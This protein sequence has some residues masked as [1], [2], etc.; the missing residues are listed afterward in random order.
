M[1]SVL[2]EGFSPR[3]K[4]RESPY[5]LSL[6][7]VRLVLG[8]RAARTDGNCSLAA[9]AVVG[10]AAGSPCWRLIFR[11]AV[12][13][14][15]C[16]SAA[17]TKELCVARALS[18]T[19]RTCRYKCALVCALPLSEI[20]MAITQEALQRSDFLSAYFSAETDRRLSGGAAPTLNQQTLP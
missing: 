13:G 4:R 5:P 9:A 12:R 18:S 15:F 20:V 3:A 19:V 2:W 6:W 14:G 17:N 11:P 1:P 7:C 16:P 10:R 8:T